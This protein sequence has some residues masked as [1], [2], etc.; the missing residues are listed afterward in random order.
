MRRNKIDLDYWLEKNASENMFRD[1]EDK[2]KLDWIDDDREEKEG[3][4]ITERPLSK[5]IIT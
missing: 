4:L 5:R 3:V 2:Q 1:D